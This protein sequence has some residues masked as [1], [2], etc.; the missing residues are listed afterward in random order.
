MDDRITT[1][2]GRKKRIKGHTS[3]IE[4]NKLD[5][6]SFLC[7]E[8]DIN[9]FCRLSEKEE[10]HSNV[11][12]AVSHGEGKHNGNEGRTC[13]R[14]PRLERSHPK[15]GMS[16]LSRTTK[17]GIAWKGAAW[18]CLENSYLVALTQNEDIP[19]ERKSRSSMSFL[20]GR[21]YLHY[22]D[23]YHCDYKKKPPSDITR[24][25]E[26]DI[27][28]Y[29]SNNRREHILRKQSK[30]MHP[31]KYLKGK[32]KN[33]T[34]SKLTINGSFS[35]P[36]CR[37]LPD[38][39]ITNEKEKKLI[40]ES[41]HEN[42]DEKE[43]VIISPYIG[44]TQ[45]QNDILE[46]YM[47]PMG[48]G[49]IFFRDDNKKSIDSVFW[50][51]N[52]CDVT[53]NSEGDVVFSS[54]DEQTL[55]RKKNS[56]SVRKRR[57]KEYPIGVLTNGGIKEMAKGKK[58]KK[59]SLCNSLIS[60]IPLYGYTSSDQSDMSFSKFFPYCEGLE[61]VKMKRALAKGKTPSRNSPN[62]KA[63]D[64]NNPKRGDQNNGMAI[65]HGIMDL[66]RQNKIFSV[67]QNKKGDKKVYACRPSNAVK[68]NSQ[69]ASHRLYC[70][71]GKVK[72]DELL[73]RGDGQISSDRYLSACVD[74][75]ETCKG[76]KEEL[77]LKRTPT[78]GKN[79]DGGIHSDE[80]GDYH[81]RLSF[82]PCTLQ[83]LK[84]SFSAW[85]SSSKGN[86][87]TEGTPQT[88]KMQ[89][90]VFHESIKK[91]KG[92]YMFA[93]R[94]RFNDERMEDKILTKQVIT[95][96][97]KMDSIHLQ[98]FMDIKRKRENNV[99]KMQILRGLNQAIYDPS[100]LEDM[101]RQ[102]NRDAHGR[103]G[104]TKAG[105]LYF[106]TLGERVQTQARWQEEK[107]GIPL[108]VAKKG[109]PPKVPKSG[110][111]RN[112]AKKGTSRQVKNARERME[113]YHRF[114]TI[115]LKNSTWLTNK[116]VSLYALGEYDLVVELYQREY[117]Q[118]D[119]YL[120][121]IYTKSLLKLRKYHYFLEYIFSI[122]EEGL[123]KLSKVL[124]HFLLGICY[125]K[126]QNYKLS[127]TEYS[128]VVVHE[129]DKGKERMHNQLCTHVSK[130]EH[131][132]EP[133]E[134]H[135]FVFICLDKLIGTYQL[136][137]HEEITLLKFVKM[138]YNFGKLINFY[139]SKLR[140]MEDVT[141][142]FKESLNSKK[143]EMF[144]KTSIFF[145]DKNCFETVKG[146]HSADKEKKAHRAPVNME[147]KNSLHAYYSSEDLTRFNGRDYNERKSNVEHYSGKNEGKGGNNIFLV[148]PQMD[149][150]NENV[151]I[152]KD[153]EK[154]CLSEKC[155]CFQ[156]KYIHQSNVLIAVR[157]GVDHFGGREC[158]QGDDQHW[159]YHHQTGSA[160]EQTGIA[161]DQTG[162]ADD[163]T[164]SAIDQTDSA[165]DQTSNDDTLLRE[166]FLFLF[167]KITKRRDIHYYYFP[168]N[169]GHLFFYVFQT[170][171]HARCNRVL[172]KV[173]HFVRMK[174]SKEYILNSLRKVG[175]HLSLIDMHS[176]Q[177][178]DK[179]G[180]K[181]EIGII[182]TKGKEGNY[183]KPIFYAPFGSTWIDKL[184]LAELICMN[185][186]CLKKH[187]FVHAYY[188]SKYI[189]RREK[190]YGE[191]A[192][193]L[194][195]ESLTNLQD[196]FKSKKRKIRELLL[197]CSERATYLGRKN[198]MYYYNPDKYM[199]KKDYLD[200]YMYGIIF[201]L[202]NDLKKASFYFK[203]CVIWKRKFYPC[204][205][206]LLRI[207]MIDDIL[208]SREKK[209]V[210]HKC[211]KLKLY[212]VLPYL[213]YCSS[214]VKKMQRDLNGKVQKREKYIL[215]STNFLKEMLTKGLN[216]DR[217][218]LFLYNELFVYNFLRGD[219]SQCEIILRNIFKR[220]NFFFMHTSSVLP[221]S[222]FLYNSGVYYYLCEKDL[223]KSEKCFIQILRNN[224]LDIKSLNV[225][226]HILYT[227]RNKYWTQFFDYSVFLERVLY[228]K[229]IISHKSYL[230]KTFFNKIEHL[231]DWSS[232]VS[233]Y[234]IVKRIGKF[235]S[236][237]Q[238]YIE[239]RYFYLTSNFKGTNLVS[240]SCIL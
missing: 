133:H 113:G 187:N 13:W 169:R 90:S 211:L 18:D 153:G 103:E 213:I 51:S 56:K 232:F 72:T 224:P 165:I 9:L 35:P 192:I 198:K 136:K 4:K 32:W 215:N 67:K 95:V 128:K 190:S 179:K 189:L 144:G 230:C 173:I 121:Y 234:K 174:F 129:M 218:N 161:D 170:F 203:K 54:S 134:I 96:A 5:Y 181:V 80:R 58:K 49:K 214:V 125:E 92:H 154:K 131:T 209:I 145:N 150:R 102:K 193:M 59:G 219:F 176:V 2:R 7:E 175:L 101:V 208:F 47:P 178:D 62:G 139:T 184:S 37:Y 48:C 82:N 89:K 55:H 220:D 26:K 222:S 33:K 204:Y 205:I 225:L 228:S 17:E 140:D 166:T 156:K 93:N 16:R 197:L 76:P 109:T 20:Y 191:D 73:L 229:N 235:S 122:N 22:C 111:P 81:T 69:I 1:E 132:N 11:N 148:R 78:K 41:E 23:I 75:D 141:Q 15:W 120:T 135:P 186:C 200:C 221:I 118:V 3:G 116:F 24:K 152:W 146:G 167:N 195:T 238:N 10:R 196:I 105:T 137:T 65:F 159:G 19:S 44:Y 14:R 236:L 77:F 57:E 223:N 207:S 68:K 163:K 39:H 212:D 83:P 201:F 36:K 25:F 52:M 127:T 180:D 94:G 97:N 210:F 147:G 217:E 177:T 31:Q 30:K 87:K 108:N 53:V 8:E 79:N 88:N 50:D 40:S 45:L 119:F 124:L 149:T 231:Q 185:L 123:N 43:N 233:Y 29:T 100:H 115:S 110:M 27:C 28:F 142:Y 206:Y 106:D 164:D 194:F 160:D 171:F 183:R 216:L 21:F 34:K 38:S 237:L 158:L 199:Y 126:L 240:P 66:C 151:Y 104:V 114:K 46:Y 188:L 168:N 91:K 107:K 12:I 70:Q 99:L 226:I 85:S 98:N 157:N 162:S 86:G 42:E 74:I 61:R 60:S 143:D 155:N 130:R 64:G 71:S 63:P 182:E 239:T 138:N 227:K 6:V 112:V 117:I 202:K 172:R 84:R